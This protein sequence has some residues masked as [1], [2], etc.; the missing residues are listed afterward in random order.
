[1]P[2]V[3][4]DPAL[5]LADENLAKALGLPHID[6]TRATDDA[7]FFADGVH[8]NAEGARRLGAWLATALEPYAC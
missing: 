5:V 6:A 3:A 1:M 2:V 8:L 7:R 4:N